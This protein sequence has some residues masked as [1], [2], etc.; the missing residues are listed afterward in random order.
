MQDTRALAIDA[1]VKIPV[2]AEFVYANLAD[3]A[4]ARGLVVFAHGSGS[5]RRSPRNALVASALQRAQFG[6]L[7]LDLLTPDEEQ[8][9]LYTREHRFDIPL[10]ANRLVA[11]TRWVDSQPALHARAIGYFG[12]STGSAAALVAAAELGE[13][14]AAVVSRGGRPDLAADVLPRVSA[15]TLLVVGGR[16]DVVIDLNEGAYRALRCAK[17]LVLVPGATHLFEEPGALERVCE[18]AI[19]WFSRHLGARVRGGPGKA[20]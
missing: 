17:D 1:E 3:P 4:G 14:I 16:D 18:L 6:T 5:S 15:A 13:R 10:L 9:D 7:L 2:G 11:A 20:P 12:A 8:R 19:E